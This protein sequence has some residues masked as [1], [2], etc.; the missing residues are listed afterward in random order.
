[1]RDAAG[2]L[3]DFE[4][5]GDLALG[6][7]EDLSVLLADDPRQGVVLAVQQFEEL[8]HDASPGQRRG[9]GPAATRPPPRPPRPVAHASAA[10]GDPLHLLSRRRV[11][12]ISP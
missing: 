6:V 7:G 8:E 3:D 9:P 5:A 1:M 12:D 4:T 2:E 10:K 11:D